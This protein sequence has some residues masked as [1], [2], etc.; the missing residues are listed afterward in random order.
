MFIGQAVCPSGIGAAAGVRRPQVLCSTA[1]V[2]AGFA[3]QRHRDGIDLASLTHVVLSHGHYDH[4]GGVGSLPRYATPIP[5]IACPDVF[6]E[7]ATSCQSPSGDA[8]SIAC[9]GAGSGV[10]GGQRFAPHCSAADPV[11]ISDRLVF[12]GGIVRRDRPPSLLGYIVRADGWRK[13][14]S[15]M[16]LAYI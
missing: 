5:L 14:L 8:T 13:T 9:R 12:L 11:W 1:A 4:V 16:T 15:A 3:S 2:A 10:A 7:R 6:N